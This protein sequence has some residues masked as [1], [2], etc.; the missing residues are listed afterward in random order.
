MIDSVEVRLDNEWRE[1]YQNPLRTGPDSAFNSHLAASYYPAMF[2][3]LE[4]FLAYDKPWDEAF[5][6]VPGTP[7]AGRSVFLWGDL[8][9]VIVLNRRDR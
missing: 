5:Q 2:N 9:L 8:Q 7:W 1:Q 6:D 3:D 4:L